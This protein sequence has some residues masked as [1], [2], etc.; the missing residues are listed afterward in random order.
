MICYFMNLLAFMAVEWVEC[1]YRSQSTVSMQSQGS[2][3]MKYQTSH[4]A[5]ENSNIILCIFVKIK[6]KN[7]KTKKKIYANKQPYF[8]IDPAYPIHPLV[9]FCL[10]N[11]KYERDD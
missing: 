2:E 6:F 8:E 1:C 3:T 7:K 11:D 5:I 4:I 9:A 10:R